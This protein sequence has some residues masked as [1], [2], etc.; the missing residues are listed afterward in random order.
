LGT[1]SIAWSREFMISGVEVEDVGA[2]IPGVGWL[3]F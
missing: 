3:G 1:V 2:F